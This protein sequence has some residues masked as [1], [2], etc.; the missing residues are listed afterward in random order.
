MNYESPEKRSS[1]KSRAG[2]TP[3]L[4][5]LG[6]NEA[7][8]SLALEVLAPV[9]RYEVIGADRWV[10][11]IDCAAT[12]LQWSAMARF[13]DPG[14]RLSLVVP[15]FFDNEITK[16]YLES[17]H[18]LAQQRDRLVGLF[19]ARSSTDS[20]GVQDEIAM[21]E[22]TWMRHLHCELA[23]ADFLRVGRTPSFEK[24]GADQAYLRGDE[25]PSGS[26]Q[27]HVHARVM[28]GEIE[29]LDIS[30]TRTEGVP[31]Q[32][33]RETTPRVL[34]QLSSKLRLFEDLNGQ[35]LEID[36]AI[37]DSNALGTQER[38]EHQLVLHTSQL[39]AQ[40]LSGEAGRSLNLDIELDNPPPVTARA[41]DRYPLIR[42]SSLRALSQ[43]APSEF[44]AIRSESDLQG[45]PRHQHWTEVT[46]GVPNAS[47]AREPGVLGLLA[48]SAA[49][50][51]AMLKSSIA[52]APQ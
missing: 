29:P 34:L 18:F 46:L 49:P 12:Y 23:A 45:T 6:L 27:E 22:E 37:Y 35:L 48:A 39:A 40:S 25:P 36:R 26:V 4:T 32:V 31:A 20:G 5:E 14:V 42:S 9:D 44:G 50:H 19:D 28:W 38:Q 11:L 10:R 30:Q 21:H 7:E 8:I 3:R 15:P 13:Q 51:L 43:S 52:D 33:E 24:S 16:Q 47:Y 1:P 17:T 41:I 2:A